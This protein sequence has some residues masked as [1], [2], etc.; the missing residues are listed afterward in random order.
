M[1]KRINGIITFICFVCL[2]IG[3]AGVDADKPQSAIVLI[4]IGLVGIISEGFYWR[5]VYEH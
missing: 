5:R 1:R 3:A 4:V 2:L